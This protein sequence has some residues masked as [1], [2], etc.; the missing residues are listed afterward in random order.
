[1]LVRNGAKFLEID[2]KDLERFE[3]AGFVE[4]KPKTGKP[5]DEKPKGGK[6]KGEKSGDDVKSEDDM[7]SDEV[8]ESEGDN[9]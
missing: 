2:P 9:K 8:V 4:F 6:P 7:E 3:A 5:K 1:M